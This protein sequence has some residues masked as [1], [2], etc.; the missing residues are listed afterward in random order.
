MNIIIENGEK[1]DTETLCTRGFFQTIQYFEFNFFLLIFGNILPRATILF[2]ILETKIF[3]VTYCN[4]KILDFIN[5]L[6]NM[7]NNFNQIWSKS[8]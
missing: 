1:W 3:D 7:R 6:K 4:T 8:E 2:N 5:H